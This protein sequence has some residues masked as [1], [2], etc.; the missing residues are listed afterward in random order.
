MPIKITAKK[1]GFRRCG[2]A[3][4][5]AT[6]THPDDAFT[7]DQIDILMAEPALVVEIIQG[8]EPEANPAEKKPGKK[9]KSEPGA[10]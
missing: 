7:E 8:D 3:H 9:A 1:D 2:V 5:M 10:E 6:T 4:P